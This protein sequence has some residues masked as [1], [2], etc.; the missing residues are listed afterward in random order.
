MPVIITASLFLIFICLVLF[1]VMMFVTYDFGFIFRIK[2]TFRQ[3]D[4]G[5]F[6][7]NSYTYI[8]FGKNKQTKIPAKDGIKMNEH[9]IQD[10]MDTALRNI[11]QMVDVNTII[12]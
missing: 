4:M 10:L 12:G 7:A 2:Y 9:P 1:S 11:R 5:C 3:P 8:Y 6:K